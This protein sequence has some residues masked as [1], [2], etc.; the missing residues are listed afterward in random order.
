MTCGLAN[1]RKQ[2]SSVH[3]NLTSDFEELFSPAWSV[4]V[5]K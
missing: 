3:K 5:E 2:Y 1:I 4:V